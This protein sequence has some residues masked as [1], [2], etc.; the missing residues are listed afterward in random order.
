[1]TVTDSGGLTDAQDI[2]VTVTNVNEA[3]AISS[4]AA[5]NAT[6]NQTAVRR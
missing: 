4:A 2:A 6:E 3:P 5:V 1:M